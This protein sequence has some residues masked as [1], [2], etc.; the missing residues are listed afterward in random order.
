M[1]FRRTLLASAAAAVLGLTS[2]PISAQSREMRLLTGWDDRSEVVTQVVVPLMDALEAAAEGDLTLQRF[3]PETIPPFEQLDPVG[4]GVFDFL[5]TN[6]AYHYNQS[7][8]AMAVEAFDVTPET[9]RS[10]GLWDYV[11]RHYQQFGV[12]LLAYLVDPNGYSL[13]LREP[14]SGDALAGRRIRGT[15]VYHPLIEALGGAPVVLPASEIY[16]ALERGVVDGAAWPLVGPYGFRWFEVTDYMMR[17]AFGRVG[18]PVFVSLDRWNALDDDLRDR[19][20]QAAAD[21]ELSVGAT[22]DAMVETEEAALLAE[23]MKVTELDEARVATLDVSWFEGV[24]AL[25]GQQNPDEVSEMTEIGR[26]AGLLP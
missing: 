14:L 24:L 9:L 3:G 15:P 26:S 8:V 25:A 16:P 5:F 12:K 23:G 2:G 21:Y 22:F 1:M 19:L 10:S 18:Y 20:A 11:D 13:I 6:G 7:A 17:P 4:R